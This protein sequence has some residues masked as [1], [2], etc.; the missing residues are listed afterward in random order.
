MKTKVRR[1]GSSLGV[2]L[3]KKV[4]EYLQV[5]EGRE[6]QIIRSVNGIELSKMSEETSQVLELCKKIY[7]ENEEWFL[8]MANL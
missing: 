8:M 4:I 3:P 5:E 7:R 2:C 1:I 6:L